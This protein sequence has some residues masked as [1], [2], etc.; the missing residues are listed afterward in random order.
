[1]TWW[2]HL[3]VRRCETLRARVDVYERVARAVGRIRYGE[4]S[5]PLLMQRTLF[6]RDRYQT[7]VGLY[8]ENVMGNMH[9]CG[10]APSLVGVDGTLGWGSQ[11]WKNYP[12]I[13]PSF[14]TRRGNYGGS[15][16]IYREEFYHQ[17]DANKM[18]LIKYHVNWYEKGLLVHFAV[19]P[20]W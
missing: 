13:K 14:I 10:S 20:P 18:R 8:V 4:R 9:P 16:D 15:D 12:E 6:F 3:L 1:M 5:E 11:V 19:Q 7:T 2:F 17:P